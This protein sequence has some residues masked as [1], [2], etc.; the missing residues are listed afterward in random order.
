[1]P[2]SRI[3]LHIKSLAEYVIIILKG[4]AEFEDSISSL[5]VFL[6]SENISF[7]NERTQ[8]KIDLHVV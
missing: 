8:V 6:K 7:I 4:E 5:V 3:E 1:M 2:P